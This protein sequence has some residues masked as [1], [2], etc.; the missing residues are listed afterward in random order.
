VINNFLPTLRLL[1]SASLVGFSGGL[2][3]YLAFLL[4]GLIPPIMLVVAACLIIYATYTLDRA[5]ENKEDVINH[6]EFSGADKRAGLVASGI[7]TIS[8]SLLFFSEW[9]ISP[10]LFPFL[11]GILYSKGIPLGSTVIK[12]KGGCGGKNLVIGITWGGTIGLV[13][14]AFAPPLAALVIA[15]Y[16]GMKLFINSTI[17]DL[18]DIEGDL[19]AGI[20]TLPV[21]LGS[22]YLKIFLLAICLV[23]H[24][25]LFAAM[26]TGLLAGLWWLL[27]YS[28]AASCL[29]IVWY[30]PAFETS[31]SWLKRKIR[32]L[33]I[34]Y[35]PIMLAVLS[36]FLP[37]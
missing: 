6:P 26:Y 35:E 13:I 21:V 22:R 10:P 28:L 18:K 3:L 1:N 24:A 31:H 14:A 32:I 9:L 34:N 33:A 29:V 25:I 23:Q 17:F 19:A 16:F 20:R 37:A 11:V 30:S 2:R 4:A 8:G 15:A 5:L 12:L 36:V 27:L 7:C